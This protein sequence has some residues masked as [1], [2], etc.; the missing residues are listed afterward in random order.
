[1]MRLPQMLLATLCVLLGLFP[2]V[3][4]SIIHH[5]LQA[6]QQGFGTILAAVNPG[7]LG[8][9]AGRARFGRQGRAGAAGARDRGWS[10]DPPGARPAKLGGAPRRQAVPW[11]C[12]YA[13]E[14]YAEPVSRRSFLRRVETLFPLAGRRARQTATARTGST[15]SV[16]LR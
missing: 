15:P 3:A 12:G 2:M 16:S 9:L 13:R 5:A 10:S 1:M 14:T 7:H 4:L 6:S 11:L 8:T